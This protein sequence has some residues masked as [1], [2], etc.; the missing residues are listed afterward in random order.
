MQPP[1]VEGEETSTEDVQE[2]TEEDVDWEVTTNPTTRS[3][4]LGHGL[5]QVSSHRWYVWPFFLD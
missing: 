1:I 3:R 2:T 4:L 5:S